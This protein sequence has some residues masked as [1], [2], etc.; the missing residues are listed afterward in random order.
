MFH[1]TI[2]PYSYL[3]SF[4]ILLPIVTKTVAFMQVR[5][6]SKKVMKAVSLIITNIIQHE[7]G[8]SNKRKHKKN[9]NTKKIGG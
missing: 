3:D 6:S 8:K 2:L 5:V 4:P 9:K 1:I 7:F